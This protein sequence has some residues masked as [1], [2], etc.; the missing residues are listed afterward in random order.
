MSEFL[1]FSNAYPTTRRKGGD[2]AHDLFK[3]ARRKVSFDVLLRALEQ[4]KRS[5]QWQDPRFIPSM[6]TWLRDEMWIQVLPEPKAPAARLTPYQQAQ[7][8]GLK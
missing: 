6:L 3:K 4:H 1:Q 2:R 8:Q 5:D 7:R